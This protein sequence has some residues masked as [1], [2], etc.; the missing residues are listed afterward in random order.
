M[1][2]V[3][4]FV[5]LPLAISGDDRIVITASAA[6]DDRRVRFHM[7]Q[8]REV[9]TR[10]GKLIEYWEAQTLVRTAVLSG[11]RVGGRG[12]VVGR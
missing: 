8:F 10:I 9:R 1:D 12:S 2:L 5:D 3:D 7:P 11:G 4:F 6:T